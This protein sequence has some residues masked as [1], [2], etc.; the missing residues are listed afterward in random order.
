MQTLQSSDILTHIILSDFL[1]YIIAAGSAYLL[2]WVIFKKQWRRHIIQQKLPQAK[3]MWFEFRYSMSTVVIFALVGFGVVSA[4]N[5]GYTQLYDSIGEHGLPWFFISIV[6][7]ILIH[8]MY[9]YWAHR[10][11]HHPKIFRHV[12][13]VHHRSTNPSPWA[14]YSFHPIEAVVEAAIFP[15]LAFTIPI[16][17]LAFFIFLVYMISR[18]VLGHLGIEFL[19]KWFIKNKWVNW[20]TTTTHHDLHHKYFNSNYGLYFTWWDRWF[21]TE[22]RR[23]QET[24]EEVTSRE[25]EPALTDY[26]AK[27]RILKIG[28][29]DK[30]ALILLFVLAGVP[31]APAQSVAGVWQTFHEESGRLLSLVKIEEKNGSI[32][33]QVAKIYLQPWEGDDPICTKCPGERKGEKVIGME[34]LYGFKK[35][36]NE[37]SGGSILDPASGEVYDS[38]LWLENK[39]TLKVRGYSGPMNLFFRTQS[40]RLHE[41][42]ND[43]N[44]ITGIWK[45][46]DDETGK[47]KSLVE[48][49]AKNGRLSG[50]ILKIYLQPWEGNDPICRQCPGDN[51]NDKIVGMTFLWG[52]KKKDKSW[53]GGYILDPGNGK[54]YTSTIWL[55]DTDTLKVRGYL[56]PF[57]RTQTWRRLK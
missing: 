44:P 9:F 41:A 5:A 8:D 35:S 1:R 30:V 17:G 13:L 2:F 40:W 52:F 16:H 34:F 29:L 11:M 18:N 19:P 32:E 20:H 37:W 23:Y 26:G 47:A 56:G 3:K 7:M 49:S 31:A 48:I 12:H 27:K 54:T 45:T 21:G 25:E 6:L 51:K 39:N 46:I 14:A 50:K 53:T 15:L 22:D 57:Y 38:K 4:K 24:F 43:G 10:L 55:E 42:N 33:G 36:G 28:K